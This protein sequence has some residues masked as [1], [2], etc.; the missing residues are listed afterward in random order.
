MGLINSLDRFAEMRLVPHS[1][2][3]ASISVIILV[4]TFATICYYARVN[5]SL[6]KLFIVGLVI[7]IV[8]LIFLTIL[9]FASQASSF[10]IID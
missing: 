10:S 7:W 8:I 3:I 6:K 1:G 2:V 5:R 4:A 9:T